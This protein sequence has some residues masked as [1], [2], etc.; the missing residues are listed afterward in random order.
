[1]KLSKLQ[2]QDPVLL[3]LQ[4]TVNDGFQ[5]ENLV[6]MKI[7]TTVKVDLADDEQNAAVVAVSV[8]VGEQTAE[9]PF[10]IFVKEQALFHWECDE[11]LPYETIQ[12][13]LKKNAAAL[14]VGYIRPIIA[15]VT[16]S[17]PYNSF[18]LPFIDLRGE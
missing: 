5:G 15:V 7:N 11:T 14:L 17:S 8:A 16:N 4:F 12:Q 3:D 13:M 18:N 10:Y 9:S 1:M 6:N 2:F